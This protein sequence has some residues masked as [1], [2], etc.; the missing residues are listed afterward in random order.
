LN[1]AVL[2]AYPSRG[3]AW[4]SATI[5][6]IISAIATADRMAIA[7]L[8]GP[9]KKD[10]AIGDFQA[11]LLIGAAFTSF[12]ILFLLPIGWAADRYSRRIV[13]AICLFLWS[14]ATISCGWATGFVM[15]FIMRMLVGAGEAGMAPTVHGIIGDSFPRESLAKPLALQG[16]GF[17]V[18]S[19]AGVAAAGAIVSAAAAGTYSGWPVVGDMARWRIAFVAVGLPGLLALVLIPILHDPRQKPAAH[20]STEPVIPFL[21]ANVGLVVPALLFAGI[22]A[23][24]LGCVTGW[25]PEYLQRAYGVSPKQAGATLGSL[26]LLAA[27]AGQGLYAIIVDWLV[28]KG[29][30][31]AT[32]KVG[33]IPIALSIPL[34]W[35]AFR[36]NS[37][38]AFVPLL[39]G[40][41]LCIAPCNAISNTM[42]QTIAPAPLRSRMTALSILSV[43]IFGFTLGP[44]LAGWLSQYVFGEANLG[45]AVQLV[46]MGSMAIS[47]MLLLVLRPRLLAY[48]ESRDA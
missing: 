46:M 45:S 41:L 40:L 38:T 4:R 35:I 15:L 44:A 43:S 17:Q 29:V 39:T 34:A 30:K 36:A 48:L 23:M 24:A 32:L 31:D 22:S 25:I 13:L 8:I 28:A 1:S 5:I 27:F 19:A 6:F 18:G 47:I 10:F 21:R 11:S 37:A 9:I 33:L 16:I 14:L 12:Y 2:V 42:I 20:I 7:M 26:L 3:V